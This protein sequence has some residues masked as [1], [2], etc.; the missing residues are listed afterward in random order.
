MGVSTA[1]WLNKTKP[2]Q[3][4]PKAP[5]TFLCTWDVETAASMW[6]L[7]R[8]VRKAGKLTWQQLNKVTQHFI[9]INRRCSCAVTAH[10]IKPYTVNEL[11]SQ[12][13]QP[14]AKCMNKV[15]VAQ[16]NHT[17][18]MSGGEKKTQPTPES[19]P[20]SLRP[21]LSWHVVIFHSR[22]VFQPELPTGCNR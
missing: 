20:C 14:L 3:V 12:T 18:F 8:A 4:V 22:G 6:T 2:S 21:A 5:S 9:S 15:N 17:S 10:I 1:D 11:F 7:N 19:P 16:L 13:G